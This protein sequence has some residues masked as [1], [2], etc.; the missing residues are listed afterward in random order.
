MPCSCRAFS[1]VQSA[2]AFLPLAWL[3]A[4]AKPPWLGFASDAVTSVIVLTAFAQLLL[5]KKFIESGGQASIPSWAALLSLGFF[6]LLSTIQTQGS[7]DRAVL[8]CW[9][10][11]VV[12]TSVWLGSNL[13]VNDT[14]R[15]YRAG[16][17]Q[18]LRDA[19]TT[20]L[21]F[22][23]IFAV[24]IVNVTL[25]TIQWTGVHEFL[26][27]WV[28][29][30]L[31]G[32]Y[33]PFAN[34]GQPNLLATTLVWGM[35][36]T[37]WLTHRAYLSSGFAWAWGAYISFGL[38]LTQ[39]RTGILAAIAV[40]LI[41]LVYLRPLA[42]SFKVCFWACIALA[43]A[44]FLPDLAH[45]LT[46]LSAQDAIPPTVQ[47]TNFTSPSSLEIR[48][49]AWKALLD[50]TLISPF[51]GSGFNTTG[52]RHLSIYSTNDPWM[53]S[54]LFVYAHN[55]LIDLSIWFG[56]IPTAALSTVCIYF[57]YLF[58]S[59][60]RDTGQWLLVMFLTPFLIHASLELPHA[61]LSLI[62]V[63]GLAFGLIL[64]SLQSTNTTPL[65]SKKYFIKI[66]FLKFKPLALFSYIIFLAITSLGLALFVDYTKLR[67]GFIALQFEAR[68]HTPPP[69]RELNP[70]FFVL[71][72][73]GPWLQLN[74]KDFLFGCKSVSNLSDNRLLQVLQVYPT[75]NA[76]A[77]TA[78]CLDLRGN[79][80]TATYWRDRICA[81][82]A[83]DECEL[84]K[85][86]SHP[87]QPARPL[88]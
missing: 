30:P 75:A 14:D 78:Y 45:L 38:G 53:Q 66:G 73:W 74:R 77:R 17:S 79:E 59:K 54:V 13:A 23:T 2:I 44:W 4:H 7:L 55:I 81:L 51:W 84:L 88:N 22:L 29:E 8:G 32:G 49:H 52:L 58:I 72:D 3:V 21:F 26:Q 68:F 24:S 87:V 82:S 47:S 76:M 36:A 41:S 43:V 46:D 37:L 48:L 31:P 20:D 40:A 25:Q 62:S 39:S 11:I 5:Q 60:P 34:F 35:V 63:A 69:E 65:V 61:H 86:M 18:K 71:Q 16:I 67:Q 56:L 12:Y 85:R 33:R 1:F 64:S 9:F 70:S 10:A 50:S 6:I 57:I 80:T 42:L 15:A 19:P 27:G 28:R 83:P